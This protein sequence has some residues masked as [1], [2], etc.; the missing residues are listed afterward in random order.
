MSDSQEV[1]SLLAGGFQLDCAYSPAH[2]YELAKMD[3]AII[4][5]KDA[6]KIICANAHLNPDQDIPSEETGIRSPYGGKNSAADQ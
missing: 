4:L 6:T 1:M 5:N 3:G 2:L